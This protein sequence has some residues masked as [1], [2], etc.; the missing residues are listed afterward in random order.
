MNRVNA[1]EKEAV[2]NLRHNVQ[3]LR[4]LL[5]TNNSDLEQ[6]NS[7]LDESKRMF[8]ELTEAFEE[9]V[10]ANLICYF[11]QNVCMREFI[12]LKD[13]LLLIIGCAWKFRLLGASDRSGIVN[14]K[15]I[16]I[17]GR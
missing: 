14:I 11:V 5:V 16:Y 2:S 15:K 12:K 3:E 7:L 1:S 4:A 9:K 10:R 17:C 8:I 13:I 6:T